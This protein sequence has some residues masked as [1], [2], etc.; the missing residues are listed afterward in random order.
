TAAVSGGNSGSGT[1]TIKDD[2]TGKVYN[3][4]GTIN[5][6]ATPDNDFTADLDPATDTGA[7]DRITQ[8][9]T[10]EF[11]INGGA[12]LKPGGSV[13]LLDPS[14][15]VVAVAPITPQDIS[16]GAI[17]VAPGIL[18]DGTYVYKA[19]ILDALGKVIGSQP[20]TVTVVTDRD[21]VAPS[22]ELAANGGDFNKDG[23]PDWLQN[24]VAQLPVTS[25]SAFNAGKD[26]PASSFGAI[27]AGTVNPVS[28]SAPVTL[29]GGAQLID[30]ALKVPPIVALPQGV[31]G[32]TPLYQFSVTSQ[33]GAQLADIDL[34]R[35]GLQSQ[36]V[37]DLPQ[38]VAAN[39]YFKF[40]QKTQSWTNYTN[41]AALNG[42]QDG[43]ALVDTNAD[44]KIDRVVLTLTD[45]GPGDED[46]LANGTI[47]DPGLLALNVHPVFSVGSG[48]GDRWLSGVLKDAQ[49]RAKP[50]T[51]KVA[52]DFF[53][54]ELPA[55]DLKPLKAWVNVLTGDFF[56]AP[57]GVPPPYACYV[58]YNASGLG[59]VP[60]A[61][62]G[63]FDVHLY[64]NS[65]GVTQLVGIQQ[66]AE[67]GLA[68]KGFTDLGPQFASVEAYGTDPGVQLMGAPLSA[69][70][71]AGL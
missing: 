7:K 19:E 61:G 56:Y 42:K 33:T 21:G 54:S 10:P 40:N 1:A 60:A 53:T 15:G 5:N 2:G 11:T 68:A 46:G 43:A 64:V 3:D 25:L 14:G 22:V 26:A 29:D 16:K 35:P 49:D 58:P 9:I 8:D 69:S 34:T 65:A 66:A 18:D 13:R 30:V 51:D 52:V 36:V 17:N 28:P 32:V 50:T 57:E 20:V 63:A 6:A 38:G 45:G 62:K 70:P 59:Y 44:G 67:L 55:A 47:V 24:N 71:V 39:A 4:N 23:T 27:L 48:A 12:Y 41:A 37:I 31:N